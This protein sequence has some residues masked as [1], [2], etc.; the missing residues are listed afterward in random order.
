MNSSI[1]YPQ[2]TSADISVAA[3][4][5]LYLKSNDDVTILEK[6]TDP[7]M[8]DKWNI[9]TRVSAANALDGYSSSAFSSAST[10]RIV[11]GCAEVHYSVGTEPVALIEGFGRVQ[12]TISTLNATGTLTCAILLSG[13]VTSTTTAA[14]TATLDTGTAMDAGSTFDADDAFDWA[15]INTGTANAFTVTASSLHTIVGGAA[16]SASSSGLFRTRKTAANTFVT[17]RLA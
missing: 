3:S 14:V 17:Y 16:V 8:P 4:D 7:N 13:V 9:L 6:V 12:D 5:I 1:V 11:A 2:A 10:V 15:A